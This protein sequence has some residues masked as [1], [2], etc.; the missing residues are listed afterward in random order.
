MKSLISLILLVAW[1]GGIYLAKGFWSVFFAVIFPIW[2]YYLVVEQL[3]I[4]YLL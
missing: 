1:L 3:V 2:G 4:K